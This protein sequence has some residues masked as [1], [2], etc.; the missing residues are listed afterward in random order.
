MTKETIGKILRDYREQ[1]GLSVQQVANK[2]NKSIKT[3]YSWES[4]QGQ[5]DI[6]TLISMCLW[7]GIGTFEEFVS[8]KDC[9]YNN[10]LKSITAHEQ[11]HI[12]KYR[13][14]NASGRDM[15]DTVLDKEVERLEARAHKK[16]G[17]E[18]ITLPIVARGPMSDDAVLTAEEKAAADAKHPEL[19]PKNNNA[20]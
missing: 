8:G 10:M 19:A 15:V 17:E 5:P 2:Y 16:S 6:E 4:G 14:L 1:A 9:S 7:Y 13:K 18:Y 20:Y 11:A 3:I 12:Q